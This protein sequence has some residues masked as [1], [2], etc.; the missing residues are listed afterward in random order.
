MVDDIEKPQNMAS[1]KSER[2]KFGTCSICDADLIHPNQLDESLSRKQIY[3]RH[4]RV[5]FEWGEDHEG[6][7]GRYIAG[8]VVEKKDLSEDCEIDTQMFTVTFYDEYRETV[9]V[10]ARNES[11]AE[12]IASDIRP[13]NGEWTQT[14]H[15]ESEAET[16]PSQA[17]ED[18]L[19]RIGLLPDDWEGDLEAELNE[20]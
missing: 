18:Y 14:L 6:D 17:G 3:R 11:E 9:I 5:H 1:H 10:E 7:E 13:H 20:L 4:R 15:T 2:E 16:D 12:D 19:K 8:D